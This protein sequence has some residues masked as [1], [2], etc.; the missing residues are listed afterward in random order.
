MRNERN[1]RFDG[2]IGAWFGK[3]KQVAQAEMKSR[4]RRIPGKR[5]NGN[6]AE[7]RSGPVLWKL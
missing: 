5:G 3:P 6:C 1:L 4:V 7:M 2:E